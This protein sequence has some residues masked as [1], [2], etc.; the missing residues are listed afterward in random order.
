ML[1]MLDL[2]VVVVEVRPFT[3][4]QGLLYY[5]ER[6]VTLNIALCAASTAHVQIYY[7]LA[8]E[9]TAAAARLHS[10]ELVARAGADVNKLANTLVRAVVP[11]GVALVLLLADTAVVTAISQP[12]T[13][14]LAIFLLITSI[15]APWFAGR[16]IVSQG[17]IFRQHHSE[18][19]MSAMTALEYSPKLLVADAH[20]VVIA[21]SRRQQRARGAVLDTAT[22]SAAVVEAMPTVAIRGQ[23]AR[24]PGGRNRNNPN[25]R[26]NYTDCP[27]VVTTEH[28]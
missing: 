7:R 23:H 18:C 20:L 28:I 17:T 16:T 11:M 27:D 19:Y 25:C 13:A 24:I 12:S 3:I 26:T 6:L 1:S 5:C 21:E 14:I 22:R 4:S 10:G 15:V 2:S 8:C 9:P